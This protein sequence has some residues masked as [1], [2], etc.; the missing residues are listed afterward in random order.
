M[1]VTIANEFIRTVNKQMLAYRLLAEKAIDQVEAPL[2]FTILNENSNSVAMIMQHLAGNMLSR[3]TDYKTTDGEKPWRERDT[4]FEPNYHSKEDL[5][6][7]WNKG[8]TCFET[9]IKNL[10]PEELLDTIL[11][12]GEKHTVIDAVNRQLAHYPYHIGQIIFL[13]KLLKEKNWDTLSI[14]KNKS[15]DYNDERFGK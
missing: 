4:E 12:R 2:L 1:E 13:C 7:F 5:L 8:W 11:I 9:A 10:K 15:K 3:W 6:L 14:A